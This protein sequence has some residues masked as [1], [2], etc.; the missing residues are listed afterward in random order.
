MIQ[1]LILLHF[2]NDGMCL[3]I[4]D[5]NNIN[6]DDDN[7]DEDDPINIVFVRDIAWC[8]RFKQHKTCKK[9]IGNELASNKSVRLV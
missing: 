6:F 8:N 3:V 4:I 1:T 9:K 2:F 7:F 5:L